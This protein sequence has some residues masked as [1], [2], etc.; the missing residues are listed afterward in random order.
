MSSFF[1]AE[2]LPALHQNNAAFTAALTKI[3]ESLSNL[4]VIRC[5]S[6]HYDPPANFKRLFPPS[7][8]DLT[9]S[10]AKLVE[11]QTWLK[12]LTLVIVPAD[13]PGMYTRYDYINDRIDI[14]V[15]VC[16]TPFNF[17][18]LNSVYNTVALQPLCSCYRCTQGPLCFPH[19]AQDPP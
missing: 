17:V 11:I 12:S 6:Y 3:K 9:A 13:L 18:C 1:A 5:L 10:N 8:P 16:E 15:N 7:A 19:L 4:E 14:N 2:T